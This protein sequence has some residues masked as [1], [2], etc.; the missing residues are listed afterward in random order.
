MYAVC[1]NQ[2]IHAGIR[3]AVTEMQTLLPV[4][5]HLHINELVTKANA[6]FIVIAIVIRV[7]AALAADE[8]LQQMRT[9]HAHS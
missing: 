4:L 3:G 8:C 9:T 1:S 5:V 6:R 2:D 7:A